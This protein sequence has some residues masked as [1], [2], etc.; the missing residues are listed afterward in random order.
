MKKINFTKMQS[1]GNDFIVVDNLKSQNFKPNKK[2][3]V[4]LCDRNYGVGCDQLL[5]LNK[6]QKKDIDFKY[7]I[8]NKDGSESGQC[9]NGGKCVAKYFFDNYKSKEDVVN[10]E[11][12]SRNIKLYKLKNNYFMID[13]GKP[14]LK[15]KDFFSKNNYF[16]Y[17][18]NKYFFY[19]VELGNPH[20]IFFVRKLNKFDIEEFSNKFLK[21]GLFRKGANISFVEK[22][23][24]GGWKA[25]IYER[26]AGITKSCGSAACA[27]AVSSKSLRHPYKKSNYVHMQ[28][29][30]ALVKWSGNIND[31][32]F[33]VGKAEYT[34]NGNFIL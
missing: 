32:V 2:D 5:I 31:S 11:T 28:G 6:S 29:G 7:Q 17:K 12:I 26:G 18:E 3:I 13:M 16:N 22:I 25:N 19:T 10:V 34:F 20:A 14:N 8:F 4:K 23:S 33:L 27:I 9:G 15:P 1:L 30:K 24:D 21:K